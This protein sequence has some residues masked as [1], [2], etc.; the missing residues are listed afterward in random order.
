MIVIKVVRE[1]YE[2]NNI[3]IISFT[4]S[5]INSFY[6]LT[7]FKPFSQLWSMLDSG[8]F[9]EEMKHG[10]SAPIKENILSEWIRSR[11]SLCFKVFRSTLPM[12]PHPPGQA[13]TP[14]HTY[15]H[16][17]WHA[18]SLPSCFSTS[19][20]PSDQLSTP[21]P[22]PLKSQFYPWNDTPEQ[23]LSKMGFALSKL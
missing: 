4:R 11:L 17:R 3:I 21:F 18:L 9:H 20:T 15:P 2:H 8:I 14:S 12:F 10:W 7:H 16:S 6:R 13:Q 1:I 22:P 19:T 5:E 23:T